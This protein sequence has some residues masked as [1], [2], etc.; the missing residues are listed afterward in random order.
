M[1]CKIYGL[2]TDWQPLLQFVRPYRSFSVCT[3]RTDRQIVSPLTKFNEMQFTD[4]Q[5]TDSLFYNQYRLYR[6][7]NRFTPW[8]T[9]RCIQLSDRQRIDFYFFSLTDRT[10][11]MIDLTD[12]ISASILDMSG[13][14]RG[15]RFV[16][17]VG[18][19]TK[20]RP[21]SNLFINAYLVAP[22]FCFGRESCSSLFRV[23]SS[24]FKTILTGSSFCT[25][26]RVMYKTKT[27][28]KF[29]DNCKSWCSLFL[30]WSRIM[31]EPF[32]SDFKT[33]LTGSSFLGLRS[34]V[35]VLYSP[36]G[37]RPL[38]SQSSTAWHCK[39]KKERF[40]KPVCM[41]FA[42]CLSSFINLCKPGNS[43][44]KG[45][46]SSSLSLSLYAR[47]SSSKTFTSKDSLNASFF[48]CDW[49]WKFSQMAWKQEDVKL[50][51]DTI[52]NSSKGST[53]WHISCV[54]THSSNKTKTT[55]LNYFNAN[56]QMPGRNSLGNCS[57]KTSPS[58]SGLRIK[59]NRNFLFSRREVSA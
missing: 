15:L 31:F 36:L 7:S 42:I 6:S 16:L 37:E 58:L 2:S 59:E 44:V 23:I 49:S 40:A 29:V 33:I 52:D 5:Q 35:F 55:F 21:W 20:R 27:L 28:V 12:C 38:L 19:C 34:S 41:L 25:F 22:C 3:D 30:L 56:S 8:S 50:I 17:F 24:N 4:C 57:P 10:D 43:T 26:G 51:S 53:P 47:V 54:I 11:R 32:L 13:F 45:K 9:N 46:Y 1:R 18:L 48:F 14:W 39:L